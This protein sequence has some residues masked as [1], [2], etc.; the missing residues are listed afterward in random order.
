VSLPPPTDPSASALPCSD[1]CICVVFAD[2]HLIVVDKPAGMP[3][4]PARTSLDP[5]CVA[6]HVREAFGFVEAVHRLDRDTS[7]LL[8]MAR[9]AP[10]RAACK[11]AASPA[12]P[13]PMTSTST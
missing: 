2:E 4:V 5:P 12:A 1:A 10:A 6:S 11:A 8:V 9:S 7:G 3:S 13:E